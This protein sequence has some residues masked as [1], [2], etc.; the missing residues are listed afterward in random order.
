MLVLMAVR[1]RVVS[2]LMSWPAAKNPTDSQPNAPNNPMP[3]NRFGSK[4][5]A[6]GFV[7]TLA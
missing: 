4:R 2:T 3:L 5:R 6:C 1:H 7:T